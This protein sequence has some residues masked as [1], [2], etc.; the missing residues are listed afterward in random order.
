MK[1]TWADAVP[2]GISGLLPMGP[3]QGLEAAGRLFEEESELD[4]KVFLTTFW[5]H[6]F[7]RIR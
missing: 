2:S 6:F 3:I 4:R 7:G 1:K 5:N